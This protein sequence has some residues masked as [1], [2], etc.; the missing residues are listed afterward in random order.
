MARFSGYNFWNDRHETTF[1]SLRSVY[2]VYNVCVH[3]RQKDF[4][5]VFNTLKETLFYNDLG[6]KPFYQGLY[7]T[8]TP[9]LGMFSCADS[10]A[11]LI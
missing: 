6:K 4:A 8:L 10:S 5:F 11:T 9:V 3:E 2:T 1:S 7:I